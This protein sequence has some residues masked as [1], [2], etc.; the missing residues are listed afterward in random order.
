MG[1]KMVWGVPGAG[2]QKFHFWRWPTRDSSMAQQKIRNLDVV[3][4]RGHI[5]EPGIHENR[6]RAVGV[7][8]IFN[9]NIIN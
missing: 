5:L 8:R 7:G 4:T 9:N 2:R 1:F 3:A 6:M